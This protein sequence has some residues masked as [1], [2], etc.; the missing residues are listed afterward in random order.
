MEKTR[1]LLKEV[2]GVDKLSNAVGYN[3]GEGGAGTRYLIPSDT[4]EAFA[5][6]K[7]LTAHEQE[8][9]AKENYSYSLTYDGD[10]NLTSVQ[11]GPMWD[12]NQHVKP[13]KTTTN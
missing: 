11:K 1:K 5:F 3:D 12:K 6:R 13:N 2:L 7:L 8:A 9:F 4:P 10:K